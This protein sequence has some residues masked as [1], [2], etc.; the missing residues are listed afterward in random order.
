MSTRTLGTIVAVSLTTLGLLTAGGCVLN[1]GNSD[2]GSG[3]RGHRVSKAVMSDLVDAN[4]AVQLGDSS[5]TVFGDSVLTDYS[6]TFSSETLGGQRVQ[7]YRVLARTSETRFERWYYFVDGVLVSFSDDRVKI[8]P[9][10]V[11]RWATSED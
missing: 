3:W 11:E 1:I 2:D 4:R 9:E 7:E 5:G 6:S 10:R 8:T